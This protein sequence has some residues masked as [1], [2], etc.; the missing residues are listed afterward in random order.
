MSKLP[1][2]LV[3]SLAFSAGCETAEPQDS[4]P[5]ADDSQPSADSDPPGE[6]GDSA[7]SPDLAPVSNV[8]AAIHELVTTM[9]EVTWTQD[10]TVDAAWIEFGLEGEG[11][12]ATP[13]ASRA[14]GEHTQLLVGVPGDADVLFRIVNQR[15]DEQLSSEEHCATTGS[16]PDNLP[17]PRLV[18]VDSDIVSEQRYLFMSLSENDFNWYQG[19]FWLFVLDR[20]A[21]VVWYRE[22]PEQRATMHARVALDGSHLLFEE[23]TIYQGDQG[24]GSLL[25]RMGLDF[26]QDETTDASGLGS[27]FA[28]T[29]D[30][31]IVFDSYADWPQTC[32][33]ELYEDGTRRR[34]WI[35]TDWMGQHSENPSAC[36]PNETIWVEDSDTVIWSMWPVDTMVELD[37]ETGEIQRQF[38]ALEGSWEF[39]PPTAG[40]DMQHYPH[41]TADGT[42]LVSTHV[43]GFQGQQRAREY[44]LDEENQTLVEIWSYGDEVPHYAI[45]A[46]EALRLDNGNTL[47]NYGSE[48]ALREVTHELRTAWQVDWDSDYLLG[49]MTLIDDLYALTSQ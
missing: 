5:S 1:L 44:T 2:V 36:D 8:S 18:H 19:P 34:I 14:E 45:Y 47:I 48:G 43:P 7:R 4:P 12:S 20:Q 31:T 16:I 35:C 29:R 11:W 42:L 39:D 3:F 10:E 49:H 15:E 40:F 32:L 23:T 21:R 27:T 46:G 30:G 33:D 37:R 22:V 6:T 24:A 9:V 28:E 25:R 26:V 17:V 38:G 41:Y 13:A